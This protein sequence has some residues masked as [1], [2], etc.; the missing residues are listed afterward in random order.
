MK[1]KSLF[2][3]SVIAVVA[4]LIAP[5]TMVANATDGTPFD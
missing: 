4:A 3:S 2:V 1:L 5:T